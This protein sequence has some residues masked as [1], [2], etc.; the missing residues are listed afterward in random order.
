M[1]PLEDGLESSMSSI[2]VSCCHLQY[3]NM[4]SL[5]FYQNPFFNYVYLSSYALTPSLFPEN[6]KDHQIVISTV[7]V[8]VHI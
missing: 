6:K 5:H 4:L 3:I 1:K 7:K 2:N 8:S